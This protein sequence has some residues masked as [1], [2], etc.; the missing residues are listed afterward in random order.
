[1]PQVDASIIVDGSGA[2]ISRQ[3]VR[4]NSGLY[5]Y[6]VTIPVGKAGQ[7]TTRTD[8]DTGTITMSSGGHGITTG[9]SVDIHWDGGVLYGV[10]VGTVSGTSV[11]FDEG[12]GTLPSNLTQVVVCVRSKLPFNFNGPKMSLLALES[13]GSA[14]CDFREIISDN[15]ILAVD[16]TAN[17]PRVWDVTGGTANPVGGD[18]MNY[19]AVSNPSTTDESVLKLTVLLDVLD[20]AV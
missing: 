1:M 17:V 7:L 5:Q 9:A 14:H 13:S 20:A 19:V 15:N 6:E 2:R 3:N 11:P 8:G 10:T 18:A 4:T 16:L 12:T